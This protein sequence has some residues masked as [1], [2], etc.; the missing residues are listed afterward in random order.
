MTEIILAVG[1]ALI[2]AIVGGLLTEVGPWYR[3]LEKPSFQ[4]PDWLFG[5]GWTV[6]L[7]L[8]AW[9]GVIA[10]RAD[11]SSGAH[12]AIAALFLV[13]GVLH[14]LWSPLFF[15]VKRPDWALIEVVPLWLSVLALMIGLWSYAPLAGWLIVPYLA[16]VTFA[17]MLNLA[18]VRLNGPFGRPAHG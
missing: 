15:K 6:I 12:I 9:A 2:L 5:P 11:E 4:P 17:S 16:W 18:V 14:I 1:W 13:N 7:G 3:N 8:A 10:W